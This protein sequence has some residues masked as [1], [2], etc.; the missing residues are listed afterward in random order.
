[1]GTSLGSIF[2]DLKINLKAL[3]EANKKITRF[4][5]T[6]KV[7]TNTA[8]KHVTKMERS[9]KKSF[10][11]ISNEAFRLGGLLSI[12]L[13]APIASAF[14]S[15]IGGAAFDELEF[16]KLR[17]LLPVTD[18]RAAEIR[19]GLREIVRR[20]PLAAHEI[21]N[22]G[23]EAARL[24]VAEQYIE[25]FTEVMGKMSF[26]TVLGS[27]DAAVA[28]A[29]FSNVVTLPL[30]Q[31]ERVGSAVVHLGNNFAA[32]ERE[33]A[34]MALRLGALK[35]MAG[36]TIPQILG[37]S[38]AFPA[39]GL[40]PEL[41]GTSMGRIATKLQNAI[42]QF[43]DMK[44][45][46]AALTERTPEEFEEAFRKDN[47]KEILNIAEGLQKGANSGLQFA[48]M[49]RAIGLDGYRI[50]IV[51][52]FMAGNTALFRD[53]IE[54]ANIAFNDAIYLQREF[55]RFMNTL[56]NQFALLANQLNIVK[57]KLGEHFLPLFRK[58]NDWILRNAVPALEVFV[59]AL[60]ILGDRSKIFILGVIGMVAA[61]G[62]LILAFGIL[63]KIIVLVFSGL[64][65]GLA[66]M[67]GFP[68]AALAM[69]IWWNK[70]TA[71][72]TKF[73]DKIGWAGTALTY[74]GKAAVYAVKFVVKLF[75]NLLHTIWLLPGAVWDVAKWAWDALKWL[76]K[77]FKWV[78]DQI[79]T[80]FLNPINKLLGEKD[81]HKE[82]QDAGTNTF[83]QI[84]ASTNRLEK[85][86]AAAKKDF[87]NHLAKT[88]PNTTDKELKK[89]KAAE[90]VLSKLY[91]KTPEKVEDEAKEN[92]EKELSLFD[93]FMAKFKKKQKELQ[94]ITDKSFELDP[95]D[96][97][98][99]QNL[100]ELSEEYKKIAEELVDKFS[101]A[102]AGNAAAKTF[103]D[104]WQGTLQTE[105]QG[106]LQSIFEGELD[107][108][109]SIFKAFLRSLIASM[110]QTWSR[111]LAEDI[112]GGLRK[113]LDQSGGGG[114]LDSLFNA[115][116]NALSNTW[117]PTTPTLNPKGHIDVGPKNPGAQDFI[118][119]YAKGG[120][121]T[122]GIMVGERGPEMVMNAKA[123]KSYGR[124]LAALNFGMDNRMGENI[125]MEQNFNFEAGVTQEQ[126][127]V[128]LNQL[129]ERMY[130]KMID[131][132]KTPDSHL[133]RTIRGTR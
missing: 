116:K 96:P 50:S 49:L 66:I 31:I 80:Y 125:S 57:L 117:K 11:R 73:L 61:V 47:I 27:T 133:R 39:V 98:A 58:L 99:R 45:L 109:D 37:L 120:M 70:I 33:I 91:K 13:T 107:S 22:V 25:N 103:S 23:A 44:N 51:M 81:I 60:S 92:V 6:V 85:E 104:S 90:S 123:S 30:D 67:L 32:N 8:S 114:F 26:A 54:K 74:F 2:I 95:F 126:L 29:R 69:V 72:V 108:I 43:P 63:L 77:G 52:A 115:G 119:R 71:S 59:E 110:T 40:F 62:P 86:R 124:H 76:G 121:A 129:S 15:V 34:K 97:N 82:L 89:M 16:V 131:D 113:A 75:Y 68:I 56:S 5:K 78:G 128:A 130:R 93:K 28:L 55:D 65:I 127:G 48:E 100:D 38:A 122:G 42:K 1:M 112:V 118:D 24:G 4:T 36:A 21:S 102:E 105:M 35:A 18:E 19:E 46:M 106:T 84:E 101:A 41:V 10:R 3:D 20:V 88:I 9:F 79:D 132:L 14:K 111:F 7:Q 64:G 12:S 17:K 53:A 83:K 94:D 87:V